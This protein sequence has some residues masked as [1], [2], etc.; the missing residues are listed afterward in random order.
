M[1]RPIPNAAVLFGTRNRQGARAELRLKFPTRTGSSVANR[2]V[3]SIV[4]LRSALGDATDA[5]AVAFRQCIK[6]QT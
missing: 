3:C 1:G 4:F 6:S 2:R 5:Q